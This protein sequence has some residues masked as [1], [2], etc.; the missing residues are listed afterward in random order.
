MEAD[1]P[2]LYSSVLLKAPPT[3]IVKGLM[4]CAEALKQ[5]RNRMAK[6]YLHINVEQKLNLRFAKQLIRESLDLGLPSS[7]DETKWVYSAFS[8][9]SKYS[10]G[11][12]E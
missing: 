3:L 10:E 2:M 11:V 12:Q 1:S 4:L 5:A 7:E 8:G 9:L 6:R